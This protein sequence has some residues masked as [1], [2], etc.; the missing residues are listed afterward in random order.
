MN[1]T[2]KVALFLGHFSPGIRL[3]K[4]LHCVFVHA[5]DKES[6]PTG[7]LASACSSKRKETNRMLHLL[8]RHTAWGYID[9]LNCTKRSVLLSNYWMSAR[10]DIW[11]KWKTLKC[12]NRSAETEVRRKP[13]YGSEKK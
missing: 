11:A 13:K 1:T 3:Y 2:R 10:L 12:G 5:D 4:E 8:Y 6:S 9:F 7:Q